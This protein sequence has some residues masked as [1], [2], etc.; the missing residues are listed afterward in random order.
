VGVYGSVFIL[1]PH[2]RL[3]SSAN[4]GFEVPDPAFKNV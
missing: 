1:R 4:L 2:E 3:N